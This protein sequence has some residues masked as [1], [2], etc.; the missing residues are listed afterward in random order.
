M[1]SSRRLE[2]R[3]K[4]FNEEQ[5]KLIFRNAAAIQLTDGCNSCCPDCGLGAKNG[6]RDFIRFDF[7]KTLFSDYGS[8]LEKSECPLYYASEPFDYQDGSKGYQDVHNLFIKCTGYSPFVSTSLPKGH[9]EEILRFVLGYNRPNE[10][11]KNRFFTR[12][13]GRLSL[14]T[15]NYERVNEVFQRIASE[16]GCEDKTLDEWVV[17]YNKDRKD[18]I[19]RYGC[20][21]SIEI[22]DF[23][24]EDTCGELHSKRLGERHKDNLGK[25][26]IICKHGTLI[27]PEN[28]Y[29]LQAVRP[30]RKHL[31]GQILT[32]I[33]PEHFEI[34]PSAKLGRSYSLFLLKGRKR[35][36]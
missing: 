17:R 28:V 30:S 20:T 18:E 12:F 35:L 34:I 5:L 1:E 16:L 8:E 36:K 9:E 27:T 4:H 19:K 29:N 3:L 25:N 15:A 2:E 22:F 33:D 32:P 31:L 14:T 23:Y 10:Q 11:E 24:N 13:I 21:D 7:L 26:G 6:V